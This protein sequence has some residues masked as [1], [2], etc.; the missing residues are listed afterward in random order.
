MN[1]STIYLPSLPQVDFPYSIQGQHVAQQAYEPDGIH[2]AFGSTLQTQP[3]GGHSTTGSIHPSTAA[4]I[5]EFHNAELPSNTQAASAPSMGPPGRP[6]KKKAPTLRA[7]AWEPYKAR[8]VE[9]HIT[10]GLPLKEVKKKIE[11]E[12]EFTA[13]YV[14]FL[15][16]EQIELD[17]KC[18]DVDMA[19]GYDS[20]E[21]A[22]ANGGRTRT[23][24]RGR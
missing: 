14:T 20:I 23:S 22:L 19:V 9:L 2:P 21:H 17:F 1:P 16:V 5:N 7:N 3:Q 11:E 24:S 13:E 18:T 8:I 12:F 15:G 10:Q 4:Y 6:R